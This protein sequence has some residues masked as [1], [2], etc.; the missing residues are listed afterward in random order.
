MKI[1]EKN[2]KYIIELCKKYHVKTLFVF[3]SVT[4]ES[5]NEKSSDIDFLVQ[6]LPIDLYHYFDNYMTLKIKLEKKFNR[7]I[8]LIE[9]QTLKNPYLIASINQQK[10]MIYGQQN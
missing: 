2:I 5:F 3:G 7:K 4:N 8:D 10:K 6:F 1:I 9:E